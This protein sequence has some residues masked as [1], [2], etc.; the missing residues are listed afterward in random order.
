MLCYVS[1][2]IKE[3]DDNDFANREG[4]IKIYCPSLIDKER[5][6]ETQREQAERL[7]RPMRSWSNELQ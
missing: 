4:S 3:H 1:D 2:H 6:I 7:T 5:S